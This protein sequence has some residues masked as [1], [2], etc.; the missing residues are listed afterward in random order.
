MLTPRFKIDQND[1]V[2]TI[3]IYAPFTQIS[4]TEVF[5]DGTDFR[6]YSK[7]YFL[8]L[9]FPC[10]I[11][12]NDSAE[13]KFDADTCSYVVKCPKAVKGEFFPNLDMITELCKPKGSTAVPSSMIEE[14]DAGDENEWYFEQNVPDKA[15]EKNERLLDGINE[16]E[17]V[18]GI[19][20][21]LTHRKVFENLLEEAQEILEIKQPESKTIEER[22]VER[23]KFETEA[24]DPDHYLCDLF[25]PEEYMTEM[26][27]FQLPAFSTKLDDEETLALTNYVKKRVRSSITKRA[28]LIGLIDILYAFCFDL[29]TT[30]NEE[31]TESGWLISKL[32]ATLVCNEVF[33]SLKDCMISCYRR[34]LIYPLVRNFDLSRYVVQDLLT[35]LKS[36]RVS[37]I[38]ALLKISNIFNSSEGMYLFNQLYID[39]YIAWVQTVKESDLNE[40]DED[41]LSAY[42]NITKNDLELELDELESAARLVQ[43]EEEENKLICDMKS[44]K[45][46]ERAA[47]DNESD[48]DSSESESEDSE[49]DSSSSSTSSSS[50]LEA[51]N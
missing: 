8:R 22:R 15:E 47:K 6:F 19:G 48:D 13:A 41:L 12:E 4:E 30:L 26:L 3:S 2:V 32:S 9:H 27:S 25:E 45:L 39:Q 44:V 29:R 7:P 5:M 40:I 16:D 21:G 11:V 17:K 18:K 43:E 28:T 10:E 31:S 23:L 24:F 33:D 37:V 38:K 36:G 42:N 14:L 49:S 1:E 34:S 20:F 46:S 51:E 50:D 35:L